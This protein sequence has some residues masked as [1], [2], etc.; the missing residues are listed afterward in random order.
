[1][2][3]SRPR[4]R[5]PR[6]SR[7]NRVRTALWAALLTVAVGVGLEW[8]TPLGLIAGGAL[9]AALLYYATDTDEPEPTGPRRR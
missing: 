5:L 3:P 1:M 6:V 4:R 2:T 8:G 7:Y 9:A